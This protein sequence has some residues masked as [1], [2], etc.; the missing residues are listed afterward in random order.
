MKNQTVLG[1][2]L[3]GTPFY[4]FRGAEGDEAG[5]IGTSAPD[6]NDDNDEGPDSDGLTPGGRRLIEAERTA[7][8]EA[9]RSLGPWRKLE[10]ELGMG[11]EQIREALARRGDPDK[12]ADRAQR[13]AVQAVEQMYRTRLVRAEVRSLAAS[14]FADPDD[15][16]IFLD[17]DEI[18]V[19]DD[20]N[21]DRKA[22]EG[23]LKD[24][25]TRKPYLKKGRAGDEDVV[26]DFDGGARTTSRPPQNM[27]DLIRGAVN[28]RRGVGPKR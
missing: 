3:D 25:L 23:M 21:V 8:K 14:T 26:S 5:D 17:L 15:A 13:E 10:R 22:V 28:Q 6:A 11:P 12:E 1:Y 4:C 16:H 18:E 27:T 7:A 9:K 24:V 2:R 20:G 19:D